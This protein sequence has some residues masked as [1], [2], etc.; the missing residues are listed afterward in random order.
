VQTAG[1]AAT[2]EAKAA[3]IQMPPL[4]DHPRC[5]VRPAWPVGRALPFAHSPVPWGVPHRL[6]KDPAEVR[7]VGEA[8]IEGDF[9][10][11]RVCRR[12]LVFRPFDAPHQEVAPRR[13]P[14]PDLECSG[15]VTPAQSS[16]T[17]TFRVADSALKAH[18][19]VARDDGL[20]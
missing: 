5:S 10:K 17:R 20:S 12:H 16:D 14:E 2:D 6:P 9:G 18:L 3:T 1:S 13:Y 19:D 4:I 11:R 7:L 8:T 15:E